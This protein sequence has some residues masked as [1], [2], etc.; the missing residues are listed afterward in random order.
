MP[1]RHSGLTL[2]TGAAGFIGRHVC[3]ALARS[4]QNVLATDA[5]FPTRATAEPLTGD[6]TDASFVARIFERHA[7]TAVV[8]LASMLNTVSRARPGDALRVNA[9]ASLSLIEHAA[10]LD[11]CRFI[12]GSSIS[13]YGTRREELGWADEASPAAPTDAYGV[14]KRFVEIA[15][16]TIAL[17]T[18]LEFVALRMPIVVGAGVQGSSSRWR[19]DI[20]EMLQS[21]ENARI[22]VPFGS[23][24]RIPLAHVESIAEAIAVLVSSPH[25]QHTVYNAPSENLTCGELAQHVLRL[26]ERVSFGFGDARVDGIPQLI[27]STRFSSA[28]AFT[29]TSIAEYLRSARDQR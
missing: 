8:H 21:C 27:D 10:R 19:S 24:E 20:F 9:G 4:G 12:Y 16:E 28:F 7:I 11:A 18:G 25:L 22:D 29:A 13:A 5:S 26:D 23:S 3:A 1:E 6:L 14:L 15:G 17:Q 2:V